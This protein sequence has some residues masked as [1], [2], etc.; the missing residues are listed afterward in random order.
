[1]PVDLGLEPLLKVAARLAGVPVAASTAVAARLLA[2]PPCAGRATQARSTLN[3]DGSP[4]QVCMTAAADGTSIRLLGDPGARAGS[5]QQRVAIARTAL[6]RLL[7]EP[8]HTA[9]RARCVELLE[10]VTP[11]PLEAEPDVENGVLWLGAPL[12]GAGLAVYVKARWRS[13][14]EDWER[15]EALVERALP[16][17]DAARGLIER[18]REQARPVSAGLELNRRGGRLKLY[19]RLTAAV[20]L[21]ELGVEELADEAFA[22]F[23]AETVGDATIPAEGLV[24][25]AGFALDSGAL[26]D[27]KLDVCGHCVPRPAAAWMA[28]VSSLADGHG[29][30]AAAVGEPLAATQAAVAFLGFGLDRDAGPRLN[31]YL[32]RGEA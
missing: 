24:L 3:N 31:V 19:W 25:S 6:E 30:Q 8:E 15:C 21:A 29:L 4:L 1:V 10:T 12:G 7:D 17:P 23:V 28:L 14:D 9:V 32:K 18:V 20:A 26:R 13:P 11:A 2:E 16:A 27:A 22:R 5:A